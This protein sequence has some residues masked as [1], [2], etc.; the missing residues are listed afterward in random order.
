MDGEVDAG[1][2]AAEAAY[3]SSLEAREKAV[4]AHLRAGRNGDAVRSALENPPFPSKVAATKERSAAAAL[5]AI[6]ALAAREAD[7]VA[8]VDALD[9][10][11]A[12]VLMK[13]RERESWRRADAAAVRAAA[14]AAR[15]V[16]SS[17]GLLL[18]SQY[19][20]K[21]LSRPENSGALLKLHALLVEKRGLGSIVRAIVDRK[22][23]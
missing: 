19:V 17:H 23:A 11:A 22:T 7:A 4:D 9:G 3:L 6:A 5:R 12:D 20:Y 21:G 15:D 1:D 8:L 2:A 13:V 16:S 18:S 14:A 10:D